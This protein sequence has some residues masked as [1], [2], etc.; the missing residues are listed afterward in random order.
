M[1]VVCLGGYL[2]EHEQ[3]SRGVRQKASIASSGGLGLGPTLSGR[4]DGTTSE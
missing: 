1:Q 4:R 3:G 2:R